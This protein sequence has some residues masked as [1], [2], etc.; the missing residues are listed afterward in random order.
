MRPKI[1][2]RSLLGL[3]PRRIVQTHGAADACYLSF[4]DGPHPTHTPR[5]LDLLAAHGAKASFF[6][7]GKHAERHPEIV[8]RLVA[9]GHLIGNHSWNHDHFGGLPLAEQLAELARADAFLASFDGQARHRIRTPQ[10]WLSLPLLFKLAQRRRSVAYW[11][12]DSLD[13]QRPPLAQLVARLREQPPA[14][15]DI[16]LMHDDHALAGDA[17]AEL[18]PEWLAAGQRFHALPAE[19]RG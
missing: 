19:S 7:V 5:L 18:L 15:G 4:D 3:L 8:R 17:L 12:Y 13:Y 16:V 2:K 14:P 10:G 1:S 9:D 11:S 6:L